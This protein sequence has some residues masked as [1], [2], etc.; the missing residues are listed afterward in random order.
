VTDR[1]SLGLSE[2]DR[3]NHAFGGGLP[4]GS[5]VYL[6]GAD[7]AGKSVFAQRFAYGFASEGT[8]TSYVSTE[9]TASSFVDQ[10][11]SLSYDVVDHLLFDRLLFLHADVDTTGEADPRRLLERLERPGS[12]WQA[13]VVVIDGLDAILRNDPTYE[14]ARE[15]G[16]EDRVV[17]SFVSYL[18]SVT[19]TGRTVV[20]T[21]N[22]DPVS[23]RAVRPLR[24]AARVFLQL[25]SQTVG[26]EIRRKAVV[27][28][29]GEM[30][31]PVDDAIGYSVQQGRGITVE[32]R[33]IA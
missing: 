26:Q 4:A 1:Y 28:R 15:Q 12:L 19:A 27:R 2:R 29:F 20:V 25:E 17:Q 24:D 3:L 9:L 23:E 5:I 32:S 22:S 11:H 18:R 31:A 10:M 6:E 7:G 30:A 21:L 13:E 16:E 33:T 8:T 14:R